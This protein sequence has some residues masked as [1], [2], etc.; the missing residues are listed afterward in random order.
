MGPGIHH[1]TLKLPS[2]RAACDRAESLGYDIVGFN[3]ANPHWQEAFLHP[4][5]A[6]GIVVQMVET[7]ARESGEEHGWGE[8]LAPPEPEQRAEPVD[9]V[10]L[11]MRSEDRERCLRQWRDLLL[12]HVDEKPGELIFHWPES[13]MRVAVTLEDG[14]TNASLAIELRAERALDL[15][16]GPHPVL[17]AE[18]RQLHP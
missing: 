15:P 11:R 2:L 8:R 1:V 17:G 6:L 5:Q 3:D 9:V 13:S 18:F 4:K 10:G 14:A 7:H 12:A 16:E